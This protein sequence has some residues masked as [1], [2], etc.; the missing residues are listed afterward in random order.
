[1]KSVDNLK[2]I[3][4]DA[5][6]E[7][8][9][10]YSHLIE[11]FNI[12]ILHYPDDALDKLEEVSYLLK[13]KENKTMHDWLLVEEFWNFKQACE[14]KK[15]FIEKAKEH[16]KLPVPEDGGEVPEIPVVSNVP[17]LL[18]QSRVFEWAGISFGDKETFRL[19]KSL[20][21]LATKF[22]AATNLKFWGKIYGKERDYYI[23]EGAMEGG[24]EEGG[25]E[26]GPEFE[27]RGAGGGV[28]M[29]VY[30]VSDS[31]L[32]D[33]SQL[34]DL[35]PKDIEAARSIKVLFT[36]NL[37]REIVTN[38]FFFGREKHY[39]RAQ[40][41][42]ISHGTTV[43]PKG[44]NKLGEAEEGQPQL[45]IEPVDQENEEEKFKQP[46]TEDQTD[47][48]NWLHLPKA[49]LNNNRTGH[50]EPVPEE[51]D[52]TEPQVLLNRI[53][54]KDPYNPR[55]KTITEDNQIDELGI[56]WTIKLHGQKTRQTAQGKMGAKSSNHFGVVV[57]KSLRW[58]GSTTCWKGTE[59]FQIYVGDGLKNEDK[60]YYPVYPPT[61]PN[62]PVDLPQQSELTPLE[63][64][65]EAEA[66]PEGEGEA[67]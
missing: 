7:G 60:T 21:Q 13:N 54:A 23:A 67:Q 43:V 8:T 38:P 32:S 10:L 15:D 3:L 4:K 47:P 40:I 46:E 55:L 61:I 6:G 31:S 56:A 5:K 11:V 62:D 57:L 48:N 9:D 27:A 52:E 1:M 22:A 53:L 34:P 44:L 37:E 39:L 50:L 28:N 64:P 45:E 26:K 35:S 2:T 65:S 20:A 12:M 59:Q 30:W 14:N 58:P 19:Q 63:A 49:I 16:F 41:A 66:V 51:G 18:S 17:D 42:R 33:W 25:E 29:C 24:E 36:G